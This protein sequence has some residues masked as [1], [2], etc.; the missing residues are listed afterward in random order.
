MNIKT[1]RRRRLL[2]STPDWAVRYSPRALITP[3]QSRSY[4]Q[5]EPE[6]GGADRAPGPIATSC[7]VSRTPPAWPSTPGSMLYDHWSEADVR[8]SLLS[9]QEY[10]QRGLA[11]GNGNYRYSNRDIQRSSS[12]YRGQAA[13]MVRQAYLSTLGREPDAVGLREYTARVVR[14]GWTQRDIVRSLRASD[15]YRY[16]R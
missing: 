4:L 10:A 9:S 16:R 7:G 8:R 3:L 2:S 11:Y 6:A 5:R 12:N 15:E 1:A 14:D 13:A